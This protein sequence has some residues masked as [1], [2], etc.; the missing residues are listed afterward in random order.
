[1]PKPIPTVEWLHLCDYAFR[2]EHAKLCLIG[3]FDTLHSVE[4]PGRLPMLSVA[5]GLTD[6]QG[7]YDLAL[8]VESPSGKTVDLPL[9]K[10]NLSDRHTKHRAVVRMAGMPFEEFGT[11]RFLLKVDGQPIEWP[12]HHMEHIQVQMPPQAAPPAPDPQDN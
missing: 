12:A 3:L 10:L 9:P 1:M 2:D 8:Q 11:Y 5:F 7:N 6:G 4:L